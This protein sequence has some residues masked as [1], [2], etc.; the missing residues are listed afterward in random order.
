M[1]VNFTEYINFLTQHKITANQFLLCYLL[2]L[3]RKE[4]EEGRE[5][6]MIANESDRGFTLLYKY[7]YNCGKYDKDVG[8]NIAWSVEGDIKPLMNKGFIINNKKNSHLPDYMEVGQEFIDAIFTSESDFEVFWDEYPSFIDNFTDNSG[9][10]IPLKAV[11]K[12]EIETLYYKK[13]RSKLQHEEIMRALKWAKKNGR[14]NMNIKNFLGGEVWKGILDEIKE[15]H[16]IVGL[17]QNQDLDRMIWEDE[18][19]YE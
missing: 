1:F 18:E 7:V 12:D 16:T 9:P 5:T 19:N 17:G 2:Y 13:A 3:D 14:I 4:T 15:K 11:L 6:G 8:V 10:R